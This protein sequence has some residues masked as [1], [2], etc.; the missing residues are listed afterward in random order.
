MKNN[1]IFKGLSLALAACAVLVTT[2]CEDEPDAFE[3]TGGRPTV[4]Y[5]RPV[6]LASSDSL[7]TQASM[8]TTVCVVGENLRSI[9]KMNFNDQ[10][11][12]LN[13][14][15]M[16]DHTLI[17][18]IPR[19]IPGEVSDKIYMITTD[20]DTV[21]YDFHVIIPGPLVASMSNEWAVAGEEVS[22]IG[23]YFLDYDNFPLTV[24]FGSAYT[25]A[26]SYITSISKTAIT[27][28]M[29]ADAPQ[30][31]KITVTSIYGSATSTFQYKDNRGMLFDFD[32]PCYTGEVLGNYGWHARTIKSDETSLS[33]NFMVLGETSMGANG[34][35]NDSNFSFEYWPGDWDWDETHPVNYTTHPRL[36]D[37]VDFSDFENMSLKFEMNIPDANPWSAAPMQIYFGS[38]TMVS[39]S[40]AGISDIYG[41]IV[42]G[43]NNSFFQTQGNISRA[44]YMPWKDTENLLYDTDDKW[45]TVTIPLTDF[46]WDFD[47]NKI[48]STLTSVS[49]FSAFNI[50]I[51]KGGY[52]DRTALPDGVDCNPIIK[53]DNIRVVPNK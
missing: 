2:S 47:G 9:K 51:V 16:T 32:T 18:T 39:N 31:E 45:V 33:G 8:G 15:Y 38:I 53:I 52:E 29:P 19:E 10:T 11:A 34:A 12:V 20:N 40:S 37:I 44:L 22:I 6:S 41:N 3:S 43:A 17:V 1:I 14:S 36:Y 25:L 13:T 5:I 48:I 21:S 30:G 42:G 27:F 24:N 26:P 46:I 28:T 23:D 50:F 7:L 35:W 4:N 49:D